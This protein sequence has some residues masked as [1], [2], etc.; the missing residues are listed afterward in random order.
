MNR[1]VF[2]ACALL[3]I[4]LIAGCDS[5][6]LKQFSDLAAAG[7]AYAAAEAALSDQLSSTYIQADSVLLARQKDIKTQ[8]PASALEAAIKQANTDVE[9][10]LVTLS[11]V[12]QQTKILGMYFTQMSLLADTKNSDGIVKSADGLLEQL[13]S[14]DKS[15]E[16]TAIGGKVVGDS[17]KE[18]APLVVE[19]FQVKALDANLQKN[20]DEIDRAL[21][22]QQAAISVMTTALTQS[23]STINSYTEDE[24]VVGPF[25]S[26][27]P[28]P[29]TW[30]QDRETLIR[31]QLDLAKSQ[32]ANDSV[33]KLRTAFRDVVSN[34]GAK[35]N[36]SDLLNTISQMAG[37]VSDLKTTVNPAAK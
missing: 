24:K 25:K 34:K 30:V 37:Y 4:F 7:T 19:H 13:G 28:L 15:L 21:A 18:F 6:R 12:D 31:T 22:L 27:G 10:Y 23:L 26:P 29:K 11:K 2:H 9:T 33:T 36:F 5:E 14:I 3:P 17:V 1:T 8:A 20:A 32:A 35:V 16:S